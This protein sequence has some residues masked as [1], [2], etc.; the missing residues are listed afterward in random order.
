MGK[1]TTTQPNVRSLGG[2]LRTVGKVYVGEGLDLG[3]LWGKPGSIA[4]AILLLY[5]WASTLA[6]THSTALSHRILLTDPS[7]RICRRLDPWG[8]V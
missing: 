4:G 2:K 6:G 3:M 5:R 7:S 8:S 1:P